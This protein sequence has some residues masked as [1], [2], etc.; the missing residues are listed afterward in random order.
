MKQ[1]I[2][3][4][5]PAA[6]ALL[7]ILASQSRAQT[8]IAERSFNISD[9]QTVEL[10]LKF[11]Q[12]INVK[13]W[14]NNEVSFRAVININNGRLNDALVLDFMEEENRLAVRSDFDNEIL[15]QGRRT[16][17]PGYEYPTFTWSDDDNRAVCSDITYEIY[18]PRDVD[19]KIE[20]IS[21]DIELTG[22]QGPIRAKSISGFVDLS[23]PVT[24]GAEISMK[25]VSGEVYSGIDQLN[26]HNKKGGAPLVG[27][28][29]RASLGNGGP[30]VT[31]ESVSG[32]IYIRKGS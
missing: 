20:S 17:C 31:L 14:D 10:D 1:R 11:G 24:R 23:W 21:S 8:R 25:T 22:L 30:W 7:L 5:I 3:E 6:V 13:G 9:K 29:L 4:F 28:E 2:L 26:L 16:D 18:V 12:S 15:N 19:L 27:Y 32:N